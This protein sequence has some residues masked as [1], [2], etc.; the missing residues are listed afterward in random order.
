MHIIAHNANKLIHTLTLI[1][2]YSCKII[3]FCQRDVTHLIMEWPIGGKNMRLISVQCINGFIFSLL[4]K[5]KIVV[6]M[7]KL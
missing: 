4:A 2:Q 5:L 6:V 7:L 3:N 1:P